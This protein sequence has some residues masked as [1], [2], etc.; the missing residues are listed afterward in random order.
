MLRGTSELSW[1]LRW[2]ALE[3]LEDS[4]WE[5]C[6]SLTV[7]VRVEVVRVLNVWDCGKSET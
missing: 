2:T 5:M 7:V 1:S 4:N 6:V 3:L